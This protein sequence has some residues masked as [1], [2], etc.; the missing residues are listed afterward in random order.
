M[1][2]RQRGLHC[3]RTRPRLPRALATMACDL[4]TTG[5]RLAGRPPLTLL[6]RRP[7]PTSIQVRSPCVI[8]ARKGLERRKANIAKFAKATFRLL[9]GRRRPRGT[10]SG[11]LG[12][13]KRDGEELTDFLHTYVSNS[14]SCRKHARRCR[15][16]QRL[17]NPSIKEY[18][19]L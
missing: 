2:P 14:K 5:R 6:H 18:T 17:Q 3:F 15:F 10:W 19:L 13:L 9:D 4:F 7:C 8:H 11:F 1:N 12:V 16:A